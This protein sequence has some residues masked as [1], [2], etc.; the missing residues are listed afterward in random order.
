MSVKKEI[1]AKF[2]SLQDKTNNGKVVQQAA[3][4]PKK[5]ATK[6]GAYKTVEAKA[7][8][9]PDLNKIVFGNSANL[10]AKIIEIEQTEKHKFQQLGM[11]DRRNNFQ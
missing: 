11:G 10:K 4:D 5:R 2:D 3:G 6:E 7:S 1:A 9:H 8:Y